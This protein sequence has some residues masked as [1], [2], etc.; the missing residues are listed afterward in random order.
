MKFSIVTP[1][2]NQGEFI[3]RTIQSVLS[4]EG[5][6]LEYVVFDGASSDQTVE[7]LKRYAASH[8]DKMRWTSEKDRGQTH[9][10]NKGIK[11]TSGDIIGWLNSD[12]VYYPGT[13]R[14][15]ADHFATHPEVDVIYGSADHID[16]DD[17]HINL[18]PVEPWN[19]NR[20]LETCIICQPAA[21]FRRRV[22]EIYGLLDETLRYS[23]DYEFWLRLG[24]AGVGFDWI[25]RK[26]AGS[27]MYAQNKT[28]GSRRAVHAEI[29][30]MMKKKFN[31]TPD[32][33]LFNYAHVVAEESFDRTRN[34]RLFVYMLGFQSL[35]AAW[36]WN[37]SISRAMCSRIFKW[38]FK[39]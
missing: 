34:P 9:A 36:R 7:I 17:R 28:L 27:R 14:V 29:N 11:S 8:G 31:R 15:V 26:L 35:L 12:D 1:S 25:D 16:T 38:C 18:Y 30:D 19:F 13:L 39:A 22:V 2:Y 21:F 37:R 24:A 33:W 10:V 32:S 6:A 23:M 5:V 4:Q 20:M 3:E